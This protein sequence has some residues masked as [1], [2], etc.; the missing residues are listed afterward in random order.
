MASTASTEDFTFF[1]FLLRILQVD[2]QGIYHVIYNHLILCIYVTT[3]ELLDNLQF[4]NVKL[5]YFTSY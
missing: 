4:Y 2:Y 3:L 5:V 1:Y